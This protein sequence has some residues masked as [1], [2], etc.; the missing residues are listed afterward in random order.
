M[1]EIGIGLLGFGTVGAGVVEALQRNGDL[2][3]RRCGVP[4][5]L[6]RIA[7]LDIERDRGVTVDRA[8]LTT[9]ARAV[10]QDPAVD[11]VIELIGGVG[12]AR[13]LVTKALQAGKPVITA[14]KKLLAEHGAELY[15]LADRSRVELAFEAS[16]GGGIPCIRALREGLIANRI[17]SIYG[18]LN[19]TCNY[20][21]TKMQD[22]QL[23]FDTVLKEAQVAGYAEAEPSLDI[24]GHDTAHKAAVL[25]AIAYGNSVQV[26]D[27]HV[28][29]IRGLAQEDIQYAAELGYRIKLLAIVREEAGSVGVRVHPTLVRQ[30]HMLAKVG[31]VFNA[32][33][34]RGDIVGDTLYY[35][36]G[37]GRLPTASAV[38]SDVAAV[39]ERLASGCPYGRPNF[40]ALAPNLRVAAIDEVS[41]RSYLRM[42]VIDKP[43]VLSKL[44]TVLGRHQISIASMLQKEERR[45]DY[46]PVVMVT[47]EAGEQ[48]C[49][50]ALAEIDALDVIKGRTVRLRI[51]DFE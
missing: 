16:V 43:G 30:D 28:E 41:A 33:L 22:E 44:S 10:V 4:M 19:G 11:I 6:R 39:A 14:N 38:L 9:D 49:R 17:S 5:V 12:I 1:K 23:A 29:G 21:L 27:I 35:G 37:A 13:E 24:D 46:V 45:G 3:S 20:I 34:V 2:M 47:H 25:A 36:R 48:N 42:N 26:K 18:I 15:A 40:A 8:L 50:A 32:L 7:D 31:G 51:A